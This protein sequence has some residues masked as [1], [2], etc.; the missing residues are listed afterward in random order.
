MSTFLARELTR[1]ALC[2]RLE[3]RDG[4]AIGLTSHD[5]DLVMDHFLYR[6]AP[7]M[8]PSALEDGDVLEA[9]ALEVDGALSSA[10]ISAED[11]R[12]GRWDG[13]NIRVFAIDWQEP[14]ER[15]QI[16]RG[17]LGAITISQGRYSV[18]L[19]GPGAALDRPVV[20]ETSPYCRAE[21]GDRRCRVDLVGRVSIASI[22]AQDGRALTVDAAEPFPNAWG[23]GRVRWITGRA[24]GLVVGVL[25]GTG[26][27][28]ILVSEV[29]G[30][31]GD[32]VEITEGCDKRFATCRDRFGNAPNFRGEPYLPGIDLLTR[33][34]GE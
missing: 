4:V 1:F 33:Y 32:R 11:L 17:Q 28:L 7:G 31:V 26:S 12:A 13:A 8:A 9:G 21:L 3:R 30:A 15:V 6:S 18:E 34:P 16:V 27:Q 5:R 20:E 29:Q 2:W 24:S 22:I 10:A 25:S 14:D 23:G 19:K